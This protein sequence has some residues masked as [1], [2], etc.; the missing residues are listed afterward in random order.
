MAKNNRSHSN[1]RQQHTAARAAPV[2]PPL[3][4]YQK[5]PPKQYGKPFILLEDENKNTFQY[6]RGSWVPH[7]R[8]IAD[9]RLD[10][11]VKELPQKVNKM[12]R[13]EVRCE[14]SA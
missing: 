14:L 1:K 11:E 6:L 12:T 3:E 4:V 7:D 8:K 9:C 10:C 2:R 5:R 13:Y